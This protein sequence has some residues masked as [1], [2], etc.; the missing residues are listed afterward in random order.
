M[1][2]YCA[3]KPDILNP[4]KKSTKHF[5][6]YSVSRPDIKSNVYRDMVDDLPVVYLLVVQTPGIVR[7]TPEH[8]QVHPL[9]NVRPISNRK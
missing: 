6:G 3:N 5:T 2:D 8:Q 1:A 4:A 7:P 9:H